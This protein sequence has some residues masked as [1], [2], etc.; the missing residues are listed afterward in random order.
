MLKDSPAPALPPPEHGLPVV[1]EVAAHLARAAGRATA[2]PVGGG[3][4]LRA[5]AAGYWA[6]RGLPTSPGHVLA[7][8]RRPAPAA[9][10]A[11]L[12]GRRSAADPAVC[13][14]GTGRWPGSLSRLAYHV[15]VPA[16]CG[17]VPDPFALL[18]TVTRIRAEGGRPRFLVL[19]VADE[20]TGTV[21]PPEILHEVLEAAAAEELTVVSDE[22][23]RDTLHH[24]LGTVF[25]GLGRDVPGPR[26]RP[27]RP[28]RRPHPP[29]PGP[30]PPPASPRAASVPRCAPGP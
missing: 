2:E 5:A 25:V 21:A 19:S 17:G 28:R 6:R 13:P 18:E 14:P 8:P 16:E 24:P 27:D 30:S 10:P 20:T 26:H 29:A 1:P 9:G 15:A 7:A 4:E 23:W 22:T 12:G 11:R 3:E